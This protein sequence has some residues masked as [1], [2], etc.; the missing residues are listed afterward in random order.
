[1]TDK[2]TTDDSS[3]DSAAS[4]L[5]A[6]LGAWLPIETAPKDGTGIIV[7]SDTGNVWCNVKW[8][9]RPRAGERWEHFTLGA[10]RFHPI[11][12]MPIPKAPNVQGDRLRATTDLQEG[13][14]A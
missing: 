8:E 12:W 4:A 10:I 13:E 7:C 11:Y 6:G 9:K 1:M 14:E 2:V 5:S 3:I